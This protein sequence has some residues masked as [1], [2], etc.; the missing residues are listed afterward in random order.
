MSHNKEEG[1]GGRVMPGHRGVTE[2]GRGGFIISPKWCYII[3]ELPF[4]PLVK[5]IFNRLSSKYT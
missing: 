2:G 3:Y 5:K 1:V 4:L